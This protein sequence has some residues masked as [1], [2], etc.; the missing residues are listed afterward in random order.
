MSADVLSQLYHNLPPSNISEPPQQQQHASKSSEST[1]RQD[2][3]EEPTESLRPSTSLQGLA[4]LSDLAEHEL[5]LEELSGLV[6][7]LQELRHRASASAV[8]AAAASAA[9]GASQTAESSETQQHEEEGRSVDAALGRLTERLEEAESAWDVLKQRCEGLDNSMDLISGKTASLDGQLS[10]IRSDVELLRS[11][12]GEDKYLTVFK[13][14]SNQGAWATIQQWRSCA[15]RARSGLTFNTETTANE[16]MTSLEKILSS[17]HEFIWE[18]NRPALS[19]TSSLSSSPAVSSRAQASSL[20]SAASRKEQHAKLSNSLQAKKMYYVPSTKRVLATLGQG[21]AER[22]TQNGLVLKQ[23]KEMRNRFRDVQE[24]ILRIEQEMA[25]MA[26][27]LEPEVGLGP[28]TAAASTSTSL[29]SRES[30][31][32]TSTKLRTPKKAA[33]SSPGET[34]HSPSSSSLS[35]I[36]R[37]AS[38]LASST[39]AAGSSN[40]R[41]RSD[42]DAETRGSTPPRPKKNEKRR[43]MHVLGSGSSSLS[44]PSAHSHLGASTPP[45]RPPR[46]T[47]RSSEVSSPPISSKPRSTSTLPRHLYSPTSERARS[48]TFGATLTPT[49]FAPKGRPQWNS[50]VKRVSDSPAAAAGSRRSTLG[51]LGLPG[52][53]FS[54]PSRNAPRAASAFGHYT[55]VSIESRFRSFTP[56]PRGAG[57]GYSHSTRPAS[58]ALSAT[59]AGAARLRPESRN[60]RIPM[61]SSAKKSS[62]SRSG[63]APSDVGSDDGLSSEMGDLSMLSRA[64]SDQGGDVSYYG[65]TAAPSISQDNELE[66]VLNTPSLSSSQRVDHYFRGQ[67]MTPEPQM[68]ATASRINTMTQHR[69]GA[70]SSLRPPS[71]ASGRSRSSLG[72]PYGSSGGGRRLSRSTTPLPMSGGGAGLGMQDDGSYRPNPYDQLDLAIASL[73]EKQPLHVTFERQGQPLTKTMGLAQKPEDWI[74]QYVFQGIQ[75]L[76]CCLPCITGQMLMRLLPSHRR[77]ASAVQA[78]PAHKERRGD[79]QMH[80]QVSWAVGGFGHVVVGLAIVLKECNNADIKVSLLTCN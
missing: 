73:V 41:L 40:A 50:S 77:Q 35:S 13:S 61:P 63:V 72:A 29:A 44:P 36:R 54:T 43:S 66:E 7:E 19:A 46:S 69:G 55:P 23:Y 18:V 21:I 9:P 3:L 4:V 17:C 26:D 60:S 6:F 16:M 57:A 37:I 11:E 32:T 30:S 15:A 45:L 42:S 25:L 48:P 52:G 33:A 5:V 62:R 49:S 51:G 75:L 27:G 39:N 70:G 78:G 80:G 2:Q 8:K 34:R 64:M 14:V 38:R 71:A 76:L 56:A 59:S 53:G 79:A 28:H 65:S 58:P 20:A 12:L 31:P 47:D 67:L 74:A 10:A 22:R 68:R 24:R 1:E